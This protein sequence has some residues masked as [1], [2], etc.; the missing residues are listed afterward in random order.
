MLVWFFELLHFLYCQIFIFLSR[1]VLFCQNTL[2]LLYINWWSEWWYYSRAIL[3]GVLL[4]IIVY[5]LFV[6]LCLWS[7]LIKLL[8]WVRL[9]W[10]E[11]LFLL[12]LLVCFSLLFL[13]CWFFFIFFIFLL[14]FL[15][16]R[17]LLIVLLLIF[18][19]SHLYFASIFY[20]IL[21]WDIKFTF[22]RF[23][24]LW[25]YRFYMTL[26]K[27]SLNLNWFNFTRF[28][29][30]LLWRTWSILHII[31]KSILLDILILYFCCIGDNI[32][33]NDRFFLSLHFI[34]IL[35]NFRCRWF[36]KIEN[37][38]LILWFLLILRF[39]TLFFLIL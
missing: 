32:S 10:V 26:S 29:I 5:L 8:K 31:M 24:W 7:I 35:R 23:Y 37:F 11:I 14:M 6:H 19:H 17:L 18:I 2:C 38:L 13:R 4:F 39:L 22:G 1:V 20:E 21:L 30:F 28:N 3:E 33:F 36:I 9:L 34:I 15:F 12:S 16:Q 25:I 27:I